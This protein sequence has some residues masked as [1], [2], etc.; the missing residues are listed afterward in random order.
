MEIGALH[1]VLLGQPG[2]KK[3]D[4]LGTTDSTRY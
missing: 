4:T 3:R 2:K 1:Q